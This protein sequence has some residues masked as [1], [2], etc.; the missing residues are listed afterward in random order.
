[1]SSLSQVI[2]RIKIRGHRRTSSLETPIYRASVTLSRA[3]LVSESVPLPAQAPKKVLLWNPGHSLWGDSTVSEARPKWNR[4]RIVHAT[5]GYITRTT[6]RPCYKWNRKRI[7]HATFGYI[8]RTTGL[9][10]EG[11]SGALGNRMGPR[12]T[13]KLA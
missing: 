7:V 13:V 9:M 5:F 8:T 12:I 3:S 11:N 1:M 6:G 4:K 10:A 2:L